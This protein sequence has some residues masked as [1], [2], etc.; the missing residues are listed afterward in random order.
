MAYAVIRHYQGSSTLMDEL[1][2][3]SDEVKELIGNISGFVAYYLVRSDEGSGGFSVS[4]Y[5]DRAGAEESVRAARE[6]IQ[7]K[8][9]DAAGSPPVVIQGETF[10]DLTAR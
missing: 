3:R 2:R 6:F 4:V 10:I 7:E 8:I 9:P 1:E 5:Q